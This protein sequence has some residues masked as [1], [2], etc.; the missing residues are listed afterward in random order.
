MTSSLPPLVVFRLLDLRRFLHRLLLLL[1][2]LGRLLGLGLLSRELSWLGGGL[3]SRLHGLLVRLRLR[4][5]L[6][7]APFLSLL[8]GFC[9]VFR[10][11]LL[12]SLLHRLF[13]L[14]GGLLSRLGLLSLN[15]L[16]RL[17]C[18]LRGLLLGRGF[19]SLLGSFDLL[20]C[21][22]LLLL[23][24]LGLFCFLSRLR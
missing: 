6:R 8:L 7:G 9:G 20:S 19:W 11:S 24:F 13:L 16:G 18:L 23:C 14:S 1:N 15:L 17:G 3:G 4:L 5:T 10:F 21:L 12:I 2:R 22:R